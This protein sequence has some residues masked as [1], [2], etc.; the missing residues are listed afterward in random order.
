[1]SS[2]KGS[3]DAKLF[4][5][6]QLV[7]EWLKFGETKNGALLTLN[8]AAIVGLHNVVKMHGP[9]EWVGQT[10]LWWATGCC[11]ASM[12]IGLS[13]FYARTSFGAF[14]F[15]RE[16]PNGTGAIYFGHLADMSKADLVKRLAPDADAADLEYLEDMAGQVI[17]N[18]KLARKKMALFN[19]ALLVTMAGALTPAGLLLYYWR[20]CDDAL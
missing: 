9:L 8:G 6:L 7:N 14:S 12:A 19:G 20:F 10:W 11:L 2:D 4:R 16:S 15:S 5:A 13:S 1:M 17:V 18:S 3:A